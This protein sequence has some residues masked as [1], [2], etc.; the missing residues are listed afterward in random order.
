MNV[1]L[2]PDGKYAFNSDYLGHEDK[3]VI[4][5]FEVTETGIKKIGQLPENV[6]SKKEW[7]PGKDHKLLVLEGYQYDHIWSKA[8]NTVAVFD[9]QNLNPDISFQVKVGYFT[10]IDYY[11]RQIAFWDVYPN[12]DDK[13]RL[14]IY[15][16]E[17]GILVKEINLVQRINPVYIFHSQILSSEGFCFD[18]SKL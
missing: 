12:S 13:R 4:N 10:N 1:I 9:A 14:Y 2:S 11:S 16:F 3:E 18:Y 6:Y 15:N 7:I 5:I 17:S 8:E